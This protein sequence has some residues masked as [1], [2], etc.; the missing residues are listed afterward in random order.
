M[1]RLAKT[2]Q[3]ASDVLERLCLFGAGALLVVNLAAVMLGVFSRFFRPPVWTTDVAK[4]TLVWMV[5]LAAAPALKR[6][7]HMAITMLADRLP[8]GWRALVIGVRYAVFVGLLVLM[9]VLGFQYAAKMQALTIMTLGI[10][11]TV[12][13]LA[14]P[15][16]M[17]L[18][19]VEF[20]L[21]LCIPLPGAG[22][23][24]S[25]GGTS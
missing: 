7:E 1:G 20:G 5:M 3:T 18:M 10:K 21:G 16:G 11:K 6:G 9:A 24:K 13:L 4:I 12:P 19:L 14:V 17:V 8:P 22:A 2:C 15:V 25:Q 23:G